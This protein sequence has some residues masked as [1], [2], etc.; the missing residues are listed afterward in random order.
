MAG[1]ADYFDDHAVSEKF[2]TRWRPR[3]PQVSGGHSGLIRKICSSAADGNDWRLPE[4]S[5]L[6]VCPEGSEADVGWMS[7]NK[8]GRFRLVDQFRDTRGL[9]EAQANGL[10]VSCVEKSHDSALEPIAKAS[11]RVLAHHKITA[12]GMVTHKKPKGKFGREAQMVET[13]HSTAASVRYEICLP[14][15]NPSLVEKLSKGE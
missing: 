7:L 9:I 11:Q 6:S 14:P 2:D 15:T 3:H 8:R 10:N 5:G 1:I 4:A 12:D 13:K